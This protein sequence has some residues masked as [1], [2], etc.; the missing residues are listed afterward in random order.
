[1]LGKETAMR[2]QRKSLRIWAALAL[3]CGA[4]LSGCAS[5]LATEGSD[6]YTPD[7]VIA[8]AEDKFAADLLLIFARRAAGRCPAASRR[9]RMSLAGLA[10]AAASSTRAPTASRIGWSPPCC[11]RWTWSRRTRPHKLRAAVKRT[12]RLHFFLAFPLSPSHN[13]GTYLDMGAL[14]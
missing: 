12:F 11:A 3:L 1:M 9:R 4:L 8:M 2:K 10:A 5:T 13:E 7:D 6:P 14:L